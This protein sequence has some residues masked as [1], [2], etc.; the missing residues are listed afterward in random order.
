M[1]SLKFL[2][3]SSL[4]LQ[5]LPASAPL[6]LTVSVLCPL[7]TRARTGES[8]NALERCRSSRRSALKSCRIPNCREQ[9]LA[10]VDTISI[11]ASTSDLVLKQIARVAWVSSVAIDA[12]ASCGSFQWR[13]WITLIV[14]TVEGIG[15]SSCQHC[16]N[17][18][19]HAVHP[20]V[21]VGWDQWFGSFWSVFG[22]CK[23]PRT[24]SW[25]LSCGVA[26]PYVR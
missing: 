20:N 1:Y 12:S 25:A 19:T 5:S 15:G 3:S 17:V 8:T 7:L 4:H 10:V 11:E 18:D 21:A 14:P 24:L 9:E 22:K 13:C 2:C 16:A 6:L 26:Y 23:R